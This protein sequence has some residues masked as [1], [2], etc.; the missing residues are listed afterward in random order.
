MTDAAIAIAN[1]PAW[2]DL[3]THDAAGARELFHLQPAPEFAAWLEERG[4]FRRG[5]LA[6]SDEV[7]RR[8]L[9]EGASSATGQ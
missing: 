4:I 8:R 5:V 1:K 2:V 3:G 7:I 6:P 9:L